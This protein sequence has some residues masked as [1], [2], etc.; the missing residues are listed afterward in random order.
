MGRVG[1]SSPRLRGVRLRCC[2]CSCFREC[3]AAVGGCVQLS[4][5]LSGF[6]VSDSSGNGAGT[7]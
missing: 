3:T 2:Y 4:F 6:F 7:N 1:C 5:Y